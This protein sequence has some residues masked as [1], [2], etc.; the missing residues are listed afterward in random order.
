VRL[1]FI[2]RRAA[3]TIPFARVVAEVGDALAQVGRQD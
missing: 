2:A 1:C 3:L